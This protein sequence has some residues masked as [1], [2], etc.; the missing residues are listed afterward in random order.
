MVGGGNLEFYEE[1]VGIRGILVAR[2]DAG[3]QGENSN[4]YFYCRWLVELGAMNEKH[5]V[6]SDTLTARVIWCVIKFTRPSA[7]AF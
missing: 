2:S 4:R 5:P 6:E 1:M 3:R 7:P